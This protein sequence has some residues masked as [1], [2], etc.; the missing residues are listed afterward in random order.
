MTNQNGISYFWAFWLVN[1]VNKQEVV[2]I[3]ANFLKFKEPWE[4]SIRGTAKLDPINWSNIFG[5]LLLLWLYR[6]AELNDKTPLDTKDSMTRFCFWVIFSIVSITKVIHCYLKSYH[7]WLGIMTTN[8]CTFL[9]YLCRWSHFKVVSGG[10]AGE[11]TAQIA[12]FYYLTCNLI[13]IN[14]K[15]GWAKYHDLLVPSK[16]R[17]VARTKDNNCFIILQQSCAWDFITGNNPR[18]FLLFCKTSSHRLK[19]WKQCNCSEY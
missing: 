6:F 16:S 4:K 3:L 8:E 12:A 18:T 15:W 2:N 1:M 10:G 7:C 9:S 5:M 14:Y 11:G 17:Y 19:N 13:I